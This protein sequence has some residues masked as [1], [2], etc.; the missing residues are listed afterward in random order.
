[1]S[2][3]KTGILFTINL[4]ALNMINFRRRRKEYIDIVVRY[5]PLSY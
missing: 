5:N 1:M 3:L 4:I 2:V